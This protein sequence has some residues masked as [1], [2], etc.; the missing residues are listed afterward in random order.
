MMAIATIRLKLHDRGEADGDLADAAAQ[1]LE[2]G[3]ERERAGA[4]RAR[5]QRA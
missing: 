5:E 4:R 3:I 2:A 1:L